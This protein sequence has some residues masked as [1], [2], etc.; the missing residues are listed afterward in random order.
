MKFINRKRL[1]AALIGAG[2]GLLGIVV[3]VLFTGALVFIGETFGP[4]WLLVTIVVMVTLL[5]AIGAALDVKDE[6]GKR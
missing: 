5:S 6:G 1:F 3:A 4:I 2:V